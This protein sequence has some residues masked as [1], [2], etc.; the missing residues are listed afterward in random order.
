MDDPAAFAVVAAIN[1][2]AVVALVV[3]AWRMRRLALAS[4][5]ITSRFPVFAARDQARWAIIK[6][7]IERDDSYWRSLHSALNEVLHLENRSDLVA[8]ISTMLKERIREAGNPKQAEA[9]KRFEANLL[10]ARSRSKDLDQLF[11]RADVAF[12]A[13]LSTRTTWLSSQGLR[14]R[15]HLLRLF[16]SAMLACLRVGSTAAKTCSLSSLRLSEVVWRG[17]GAAAFR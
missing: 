7:Q 11:A 6:G 10:A 3:A 15:L 16:F 2:V 1:V 14:I 17:A 4:I 5:H 13:M 9:R 8:F 12:G